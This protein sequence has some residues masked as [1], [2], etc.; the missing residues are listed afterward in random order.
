[1]CNTQKGYLKSCNF[2][3]MILQC[4]EEDSKDK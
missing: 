1:M 2:I 3:S 4:L